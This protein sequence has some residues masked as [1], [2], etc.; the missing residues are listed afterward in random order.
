MA[1]ARNSSFWAGFGWPLGGRERPENDAAGGM[2]GGR[3]CLCSSDPEDVGGRSFVGTSEMWEA[4]FEGG[5][6]K[7]A[8]GGRRCVGDRRLT[9]GPLDEAEGVSRRG[10][11]P[12]E[13]GVVIVIIDH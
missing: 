11:D 1:S 7:S 13:D 10:V 2:C 3:G 12:L 9:L 8:G 5:P 6:W 4:F